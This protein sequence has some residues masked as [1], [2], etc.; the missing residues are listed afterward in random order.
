MKLIKSFFL[1]YYH[2]MDEYGRHGLFSRIKTYQPT[3]L[4]TKNM[5]KTEIKKI[6]DYI[7]VGLN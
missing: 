1:V 6:S 3:T 5:L 4:K 2:R 7:F